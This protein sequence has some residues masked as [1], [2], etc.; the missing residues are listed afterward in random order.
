MRQWPL[1]S[2]SRLIDLLLDQ[3][4]INI[5]LIG[6]KDETGMAAELLAQCR[7]G[8]IFNL[9]GKLTLAE[10]PHVLSTAALFIGN[11][12]GPQ[13]LAAGLGVPT[14]GIHS[15]VV[16]AHEWGPLGPKAVAVRRQMSCSPC[17][18]EHPNDCPRALACLAELDP[19]QVFRRCM[20][21]MDRVAS[22]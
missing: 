1:T 14:L 12:S 2:F 6:G 11:N 21:M 20:L 8:D 13:H 18:I 7:V 4:D 19:L 17:F 10:L 3:E 22:P 5:A 15:G 16:D 9:V